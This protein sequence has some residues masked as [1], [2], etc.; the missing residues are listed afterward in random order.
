M[1]LPRPPREEVPTLRLRTRGL[2]TCSRFSVRIFLR[3]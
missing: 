2:L 3:R 1:H